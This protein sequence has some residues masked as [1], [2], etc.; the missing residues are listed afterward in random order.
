[1]K[2]DKKLTLSLY[3][4]ILFNLLFLISLIFYNDIIIIPNNFFKITSKEYW[5]WYLDQPPVP[6]EGITM[7][8]SYSIRIMFSSMFLLQLYGILSNKMY[9]NLINKKSLLLSVLVGFG[10]YLLSFLFIKYR[11]EHYRLFMTLIFTE[12]LSLILLNLVITLKKKTQLIKGS[13]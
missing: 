10:T 4:I 6:N 7:F 1:M 5:F 9:S 3:S 8:V 2:K 12:I 13:H 11:V